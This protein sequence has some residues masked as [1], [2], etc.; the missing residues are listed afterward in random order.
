MKFKGE[1]FILFLAIIASY[2]FYVYI[3][4][5]SESEEAILEKVSLENQIPQ[6]VD[7]D[8]LSLEPITIEKIFSNKEIPFEKE[9]VWTLIATGDVMLG[10]T[11]NYKTLKYKN[12]KWAFENISPLLNSADITFINLENPFYENCP[13][14]NEGMIFCSD[15]KHIEGLKYAGI[16]IASLANN[17][18][19]NYGLRGIE[20]TK[21]K[22]E[23]NEIQTVGIEN[24]VYR[25]INNIKVAFLAYNQI[26]C[27]G[28]SACID[29]ELIKS[30]IREAKE[31]KADL[32]VIMYHWGSEYTHIPSEYQRNLAHLSI[33]SGADLILGNHPHWYQP[34]EI[35]NDKLIMYSHGN[36]IFDQMWS[37]KTRE[38]IIGKYTFYKNHLVD[39]KF[40][41]VLIED[42]GQPRILEGEEAFTIIENLKNISQNNYS[43]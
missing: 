13:I 40:T 12:Y 30:D 4:V 18:T 28:G 19:M 23:E 21:Q 35:Y 39:V 25:N 11:V 27:L 29:E 24:P 10:R 38:G 2:L 8:I 32:I 16:D 26:E 7:A 14:K 1:I 9:N 15:V 33:D 5:R 3:A 34:V 22:L 6:E 36:L 20:L 31:N 42:F 41:P 17:H 43:R 37:Q